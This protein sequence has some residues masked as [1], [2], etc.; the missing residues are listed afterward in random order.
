[1]RH[2]FFGFLAAMCLF[3]AVMFAA[4]QAQISATMQ[5]AFTDPAKL[6]DLRDKPNNDRMETFIMRYLWVASG[7]S[8]PPDARERTIAR[9]NNPQS[10]QGFST[11]GLDVAP[12]KRMLGWLIIM[13]DDQIKAGHTVGA[14]QTRIE[15]LEAK[16]LAAEARIEKLEKKVK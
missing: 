3:G 8:L 16:L 12:M 13:T 5:A 2:A 11:L 10:D 9:I 7:K 15:Q 1:M 14:L 6:T 4:P